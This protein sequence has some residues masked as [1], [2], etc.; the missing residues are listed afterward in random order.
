MAEDQ[1]IVEQDIG[2]HT[3]NGAV[4]RGAYLLGR[5]QHRV[6][7]VLQAQGWKAEG[8]HPKITGSRRYHLRVIGVEGHD[9]PGPAGCQGQKAQGDNQTEPQATAVA[10][11]DLSQF[12]APPKLSHQHPRRSGDTKNH[13]VEQLNPGGRQ[14]NGSEGRGTQGRHQQGIHQ[15]KR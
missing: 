1:H 5:A 6:G 3:D 9:Q 8:H 13:H 2:E 4:H 7:G 10:A 15:G 11:A 12:L 14:P